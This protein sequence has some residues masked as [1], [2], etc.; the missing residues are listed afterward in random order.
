MKYIKATIALFLAFI[1]SIQI[2]FLFDNKGYHYFQP[3]LRIAILISIIALLFIRNR[4][5][6]IAIVLISLI[7][8]FNVFNRINIRSD[9]ST[10]EITE[11]LFFY[12]LD[13]KTNS[14]FAIFLIRLPII[15]YTTVIVL[16]LSRRVRNYYIYLHGGTTVLQW[17]RQ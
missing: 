5:S 8:L 1:I 3:L 12:F 2:L 13:G 9:F 6:W 17:T 14:L 4:L 15:F 7:G 11:P 16:F 10:M